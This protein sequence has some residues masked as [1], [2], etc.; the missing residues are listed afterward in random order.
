M[1]MHVACLP[2][3]SRSIVQS[4]VTNLHNLEPDNSAWPFSRFHRP[5]ISYSKYYSAACLCND[6]DDDDDDG[7]LV[8]GEGILSIPLPSKTPL[9]R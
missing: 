8:S 9:T 4:L 7:R 1:A 2:H 5:P 3:N 6:D